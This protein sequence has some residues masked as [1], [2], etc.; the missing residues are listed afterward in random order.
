MNDDFCD[1]LSEVTS[2][3]HSAALGIHN[4]WLD[5]PQVEDF[6]SSF[7]VTDCLREPTS[8][9]NRGVASL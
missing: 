3:R 5:L 1:I 9:T 6:S 2:D 4:S 7:I 8:Y